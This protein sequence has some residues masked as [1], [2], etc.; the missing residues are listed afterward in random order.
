MTQ[1]DD[2]NG[3]SGVSGRQAEFCYIWEFQVPPPHVEA[4]EKA[5]GPG[6]AWDQLFRLDSAYRGTDLL[7]DP[8]QR[9]RYLTIDHWATREACQSFHDRY[10]AEFD[11]IDRVCE[12]FTLAECHIGDFEMV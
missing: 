11:A 4:F 10:R 3:G 5:Y 7:R 8:Q 9:G 2:K 6:G 1:Q 12:A